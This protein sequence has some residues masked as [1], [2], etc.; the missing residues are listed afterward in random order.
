MHPN[1]QNFLVQHGAHFDHEGVTH[2]TDSLGERQATNQE[3]V[4]CDLS[5]LALIR[6]SGDDAQSFLQAQLTNDISDVAPTRSQL[7][8]YCNPKGRMLALFRV[9][10]IN[11]DYLLQTPIALLEDLIQKLKIFVFRAQVEIQPAN[12]E[13]V[14]IGVSGPRAVESLES[15][16]ELSKATVNDSVVGNGLQITRIEGKYPRFVLLGPSQAMQAVW[17]RIREI[18]TPVGYPCWSWLDIQAGVPSVLPGN[19][20]ELIPQMVNLDALNGISF[21]K[22]CFPG[23]EIVARLRYLGKLKQRMSLLSTKG[24]HSPNPGDEV[25]V[26]TSNGQSKVGR[27]VNAQVNLDNGY[28]LL[29]VLRLDAIENDGLIV[30]DTPGLPA[31]IKPLP[32]SLPSAE[33]VTQS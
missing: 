23:Q 25:Y 3:T 31:T 7:N 30:G 20:E 9:F 28:D 21:T 17:D 2:F 33:T 24:E 18:A 22:G 32:Y 26:E 12:D 13:L 8:A 15:F 1:W 19:I 11:E 14:Q 4:V 6:V 29:A 5:P 27:V 16:A 10:Q